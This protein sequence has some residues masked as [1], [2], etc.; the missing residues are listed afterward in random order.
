MKTFNKKSREFIDFL[1]KEKKYSIHTTAGYERDLRYFYEFTNQNSETS[2]SELTAR[3]CKQYLYYLENK[4]YS[5]GSIA[6]M[7]ASLRS[8]W[9]YLIAAGELNYNPWEFLSVPRIPRKLPGVLFADEMQRFLNNMKTGKPV[10]IRNKTICE[11]IYCSG[12]RVSEL[13]GLSLSDLSIEKRELLVRGKGH[14]E[15]IVLFGY[16]VKESILNYLKTVRSAWA[17]NITKDALFINIRG[18]R[19]TV[20]AIQRF[21][22]DEAGRQGLSRVVTPHTLRHSFATALFNGGADLRTVQ[23]LLGHS[24]LSTTQIYTHIKNEQLQKTYKKAHPHG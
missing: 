19:L 3:V 8:F 13:A 2:L 7:I 10:D 21:I 1:E 22:K 17:S 11:I 9:K 4:K 20:R 12:L 24:S 16:T 18:S 23:E 6:R 5:A 15:R 14:K